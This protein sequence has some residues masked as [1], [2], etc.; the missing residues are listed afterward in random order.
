MPPEIKTL[1]IYLNNKQ[2]SIRIPFRL[3]QSLYRTKDET[4][5]SM[6]NQVID[7]LSNHFNLTDPEEVASALKNHKLNTGQSSN[8]LINTLIVENFNLAN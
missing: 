8:S 4:L 2:L 7:L 3:W 1:I 6:S 5:E